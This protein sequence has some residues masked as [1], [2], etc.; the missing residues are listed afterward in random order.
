VVTTSVTDGANGRIIVA[1]K[2]TSQF[3][4]WHY[5]YA[6]QNLT[7]AR[8]IRAF[9]VPIPAGAVVR[10][11]GFRDVDYHSGE[12]FAGTDWTAT[13]DASSV[14]WTTDAW[15]HNPNANALRWGTL[16]NFRFDIN[17]A[18]AT[19]QARLDMFVPGTP[20]SLTASTLAPNACVV[21]GVCAGSETCSNCPA[22]CAGQGG[23]TGCCG[24]LTCETGE[25]SCLCVA[26]C[27]APSALEVVCN[28]TIDD[29]CDGQTDCSDADCCTAGACSWSDHDG[30]GFA[31]CD[32]NDARADSWSTPGE[33]LD[34]RLRKGAGSEA[35]LSWLAPANPGGQTA[36]IVYDPI[37][38]A[39]PSNFVTSA[40]CVTVAG[41]GV[42]TS[43]D[44]SDPGA[45][46]AFFY[47]VR[48]T[49]ACPSGDGSLGTRSNG[50]P[51]AGRTCP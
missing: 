44:P 9:R 41:P 11:I 36:A 30:D 40:S 14:T 35:I 6:V 29:D 10:N 45:G 22:D 43:S 38:S 25:S 3:A 15:D 5:E 31:V 47:L 27:G 21:N 39:T 34:L 23:G 32:C 48:A 1:A 50:T 33:A 12:P 42:T 28:D 19:D 20:A 18:P 2:A 7:S 26:D 37:R 4:T 51:R 17:V 24:N 46:G 13:V 8:A 49:N 16:Y